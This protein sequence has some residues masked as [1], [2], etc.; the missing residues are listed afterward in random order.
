MAKK[1]LKKCSTSLVIREMPVGVY[2]AAKL[3]DNGLTL[4]CQILFIHP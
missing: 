1:H 2:K 3:L 4:L